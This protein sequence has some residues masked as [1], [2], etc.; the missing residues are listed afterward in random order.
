MDG[1]ALDWR[2]GF[3]EGVEIAG[4]TNREDIDHIAK[5]QSQLLSLHNGF[6]FSVSMMFPEPDIISKPIAQGC[7]GALNQ[8]GLKFGLHCIGGAIVLDV[9]LKELVPG[10]LVGSWM[11]PQVNNSCIFC[12]DF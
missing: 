11:N 1:V 2:P 6:R 12:Q 9:R 8:H 3:W 7:L 4:P 5:K 10:L